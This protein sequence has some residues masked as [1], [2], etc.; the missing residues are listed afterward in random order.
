MKRKSSFFFKSYSTSSKIRKRIFCPKG[1]PLGDIY[2]SE[3]V[4][5]ILW[6]KRT[7]CSYVVLNLFGILKR[8]EGKKKGRSQQRGRAFLVLS[9]PVS[10]NKFAEPKAF[11]SNLPDSRLKARDANRWYC[12]TKISTTIVQV[13]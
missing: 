8:Q 11:G 4:V 7:F 9:P 6:R 10:T 13:I 12:F 1:G 2:E 3:G 5:L